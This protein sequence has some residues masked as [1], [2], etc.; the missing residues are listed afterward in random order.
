M[1]INIFSIHIL[2]C[3][4]LNFWENFGLIK[5]GYQR[6]QKMSTLLDVGFRFLFLYVFRIFMKKR[7]WKI[8]DKW[9][10]EWRETFI[11][12][13]IKIL[14]IIIL[15]QS[16][17]LSKESANCSHES[18]HKQIF[19]EDRIFH[20]HIYRQS[21]TRNKIFLFKEMMKAKQE[22]DAEFLWYKFV[23]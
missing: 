21:I 5:I 13:L 6:E 19:K 23:T 14:H 12:I 22:E 18:C 1:L 8:T 2:K 20:Y 16:P 17:D 3:L 7:F 9:Q 15:K 11:T 10:L 4:L